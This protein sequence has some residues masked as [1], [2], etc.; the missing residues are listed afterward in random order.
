MALA[1]AVFAGGLA[2]G[3]FLLGAMVA[4]PLVVAAILAVDAIGPQR[5]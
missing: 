3:W 2:I 1:L 4:G 5:R